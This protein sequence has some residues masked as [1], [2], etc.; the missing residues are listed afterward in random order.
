MAIKKTSR[1]REK[2]HNAASVA[3]HLHLSLLDLIMQISS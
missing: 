1:R 3:N 2:V